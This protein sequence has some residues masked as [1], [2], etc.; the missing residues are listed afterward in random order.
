MFFLKQYSGL[1]RTMETDVTVT[2]NVNMGGI[3]AI[4]WRIFQGIE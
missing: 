4:F 2:K 1:Q 3:T